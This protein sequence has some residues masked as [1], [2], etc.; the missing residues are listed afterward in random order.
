MSN[1]ATTS[2]VNMGWRFVERSLS[3]IVGFFVSLVLARLLAPADFGML[4]M[5]MVLVSILD[6]FV[7]SGLGVALVQKKTVDATDYSTVF[8]FNIASSVVLYLIIFFIAPYVAV[9]Y[10]SP[11]LSLVLKIIGL[12]II[13]SG[14]RNVQI[15]YITRTLQ[16]KKLFYSS[17]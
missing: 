14:I 4:A 9:F 15:A 6:V 7:D 2:L 11:K 10:E 13:I 8:Y 16:F 1:T 3:Q 5:V 17:L 12:T